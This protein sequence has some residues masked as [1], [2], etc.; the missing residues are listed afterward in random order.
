MFEF[1]SNNVT[2]DRTRRVCVAPAPAAVCS[3]AVIT[4]DRE[5]RSLTVRRRR[6]GGQHVNTQPSVIMS[7]VFTVKL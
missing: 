2:R 5:T 6:P 1:E 4:G 7:S 3:E